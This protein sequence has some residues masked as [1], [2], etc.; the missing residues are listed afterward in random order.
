MKLKALKEIYY[1]I[2]RTK[3]NL[4]EFYKKRKRMKFITSEKLVEWLTS[5]DIINFIFNQAAHKEI[6]SQSK[7]IFS[8]L[9]S[10]N[11]LGFKELD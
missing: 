4:S 10:E 11:R 2:C 6:I 5:L 1:F 9:A 8:F 3:G 7:F